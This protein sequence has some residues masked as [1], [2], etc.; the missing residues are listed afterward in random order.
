MTSWKNCGLLAYD[1]GRAVQPILIPRKIARLKL[2]NR[3]LAI[4]TS[5]R[6]ICA[7]PSANLTSLGCSRLHESA[8]TLLSEARPCAQLCCEQT[9]FS[10]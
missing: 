5:F 3:Y 2:Y 10:Q 6:C 4:A 7:T 9:P 8:L 1:G